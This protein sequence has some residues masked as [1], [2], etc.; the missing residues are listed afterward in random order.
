MSGSIEVAGLGKAYKK[1]PSKWMRLFE[2]II[3]GNYSTHSLHWILRGVNFSAYP[4]QALGIIGNNGAGKSTLLKLIVGTIQPTE[5]LIKLNGRVAAIL[6]L[7]MGFLPDFSGRQNIYMAA[8]LLGISTDQITKLMQEIV[9]FSELENYIDEPL[10][11]YSSGMQMRLAFSVATAV[12]P[13]ILIIDEALS[14]GDIHFQHKSFNKIKEFRRAGTTLLIVSHDKEAI[15]ALCDHAI[16]LDDGRIAMQGRPEEVMDFYNA[17]RSQT[18]IALKS[19]IAEDGKNVSKLYSSGT[20][21]A[22]VSSVQI[23]NEDSQ[24]IEIIRVGQ[25]IILEI[26]VKVLS[27][28]ERLVVGYGI[29][30]RLGQ[31]IYGTNTHLKNMALTN[32]DA[33]KVFVFRFSFIASLG[34][35]VYSIQTALTSSEDYLSNNYE[36]RDLALLFTVVNVGKLDFAG[37]AWI[38]PVIEILPR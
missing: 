24:P 17:S 19:V 18:P 33:G 32:V 25:S 29:K 2:W 23:L 9:S 37:C 8:Q 28:I 20:G 15:Q 31:V 6:E 38:N 34:V 3:P 11:I 21:E 35:G 12:R 27:N 7:G 22:K 5:G 10:R 16:Y 26:E 30:D 1:Y 4:G 36:W 14:V 13:D